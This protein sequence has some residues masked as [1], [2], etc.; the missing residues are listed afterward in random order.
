MKLRSDR[1]LHFGK[2]DRQIILGRQAAAFV[3]EVI[4]QALD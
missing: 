3:V 2:D 1:L 4:A